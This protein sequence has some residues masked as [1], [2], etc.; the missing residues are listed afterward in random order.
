MMK[1]L[2]QLTKK[3][4]EGKKVLLR[5][6]FNV[7]IEDGKIV[8]DFKIKS[9]K[10]CIEYL[11]ENG[12]SVA[13]CSHRSEAGETF[14]E[15]AGQI[16]KILGKDIFFVKDVEGEAIKSAIKSHDLV[17]INN[18][19]LRPEEKTNDPEWAQE[20]AGCFDLFVFDAFAS[21]HRSY[22]TREGIMH[23]LPSYA[24]FIIESETK[25]LS[26]AIATPREGKVVVLGGAKISTKLPV[27]ANFL[28]KAEHIVLGGALINQHEELAKIADPKIILPRDTNPTEGNAFDIGP[29]A[30]AEYTN[31]I[32]GAKFVIWNGPMGK[33]EDAAYAQ[34]T[35]AVAE[36]VSRVPRSVI[37]GGDTI[38]AVNALVPS[39]K[40]TY[41]STGGGAM[42]EFLAGK[43]LPALEALGY[44]GQ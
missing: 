2:S 15:V 1:L 14:N 21:A 5:V 24:G 13:C 10:K 18:I 38:A 43:R 9:H 30:I 25:A 20:L 29:T 36:A 31:I 35:R 32:C 41:I 23:I 33:Y 26:D 11:L 40:F 16:G 6:D 3:D 44:Y 42:L 22:V 7:A 12:A 8:E 37:G 39:A 34:G 28:D 27:I 4:L 17:L 19:E